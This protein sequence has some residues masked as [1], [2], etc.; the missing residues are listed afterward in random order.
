MF[1]LLD[2]I[3]SGSSQAFW[4]SKIP[5]AIQG[6][7]F[8]V[9]RMTSRFAISLAIIVAGPLADNIFEPLLEDRGALAASIGAFIGTGGAGRGTG[10][11]FILLGLAFTAISI[12][13]LVYPPFRDIEIL[14]SVGDEAIEPQ[15]G[16]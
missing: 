14:D 4:Q 2:P 5:P 9:R 7:V 11:L 13:A 15:T 8:A 6:R 12:I 3:V 1:S 16:C 10:F